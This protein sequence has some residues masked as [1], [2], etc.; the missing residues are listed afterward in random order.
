MLK[1][2]KKHAFT[3]PHPSRHGFGMV[4]LLLALGAAAIMGAAALL[5]YPR[6]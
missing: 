1:C 2:M 3:C 4:E 6:V 5:L